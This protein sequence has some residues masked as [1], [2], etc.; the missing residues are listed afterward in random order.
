M[1]RRPLDSRKKKLVSTVNLD[2][3]STGPD[4]A[5]LPDPSLVQD[6]LVEGREVNPPAN[7]SSPRHGRLRD[8]TASEAA[9]GLATA[10]QEQQVGLASLFQTPFHEDW[11][12]FSGFPVVYMDSVVAGIEASGILRQCCIKA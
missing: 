9:E 8:N 12:I 6:S 7:P 10:P 2:R 1:S 3:V 4:A 5:A 11:L